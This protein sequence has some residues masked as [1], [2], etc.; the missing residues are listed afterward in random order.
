MVDRRSD[1]GFSRCLPYDA[2][3]NCGERTSEG[4]LRE[5]I[6]TGRASPINE[7]GPCEDRRRAQYDLQRSMIAVSVS[8]TILSGKDGTRSLGYQRTWHNTQCSRARSVSACQMEQK[9]PGK[10]LSACSD[11]N[12][13][14]RIRMLTCDDTAVIT[15]ADHGQHFA[16]Q[17]VSYRG[18][19][20]TT[21]PADK[22]R[23]DFVSTFR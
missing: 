16:R 22:S 6:G 14:R 4:R 19:E 17:L 2:V 11:T 3:I 12:K 15:E 10:R 1:R 21:E 5:V 8:F 23:S 9:Q 18:A 7:E 13:C 20:V